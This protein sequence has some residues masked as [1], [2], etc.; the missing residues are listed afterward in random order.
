MSVIGLNAV[1]V[2]L[3]T[4]RYDG[5]QVTEEKSFP[6]PEALTPRRLLADIQLV[7]WPLAPL[8]DA[9]R[10]AGYEVSEPAPGTR[11]LRR[12]GRLIAET[13]YAGADPWVSRSWLSNFE[14]GYSLQI[15]SQAP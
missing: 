15:D 9:L 1:G 12:A 13:H 8:Q 6:V 7:F 3:F 4:L 2:R 14:F 5:Q 10:P 11:R